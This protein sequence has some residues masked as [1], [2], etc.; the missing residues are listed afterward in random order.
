MFARLSGALLPHMRL[1][2]FTNHECCESN[3]LFSQSM[4]VSTTETSCLLFFSLY[5]CLYIS[6]KK[7]RCHW[8]D[9]MRCPS[10]GLDNL[11]V[12]QEE[13][14]PK[15]HFD[16][17][18]PKLKHLPSHWWIWTDSD[19]CGLPSHA[20]AVTIDPWGAGAEATWDERMHKECTN[21]GASRRLYM[22]IDV[23][24]PKGPW[25]EL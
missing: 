9:I 14:T 7:A 12:N 3:I 25:K 24:W 2:E 11:M 17:K 4:A 22:V 1:A 8:T 6:L 19:W 20:I 13:K 15:Q 23:C 10:A 18:A 16:I 5:T 21:W